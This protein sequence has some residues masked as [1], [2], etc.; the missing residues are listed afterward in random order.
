MPAI[1]APQVC[2]RYVHT[3]RFF[4]RFGESRFVHR[5]ELVSGEVSEGSVGRWRVYP[6]E[7]GQNRGGGGCH[8][9]FAGTKKRGE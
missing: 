4:F 8:P 3:G 7:S 5:K 1:V 6:F 2:V 9:A